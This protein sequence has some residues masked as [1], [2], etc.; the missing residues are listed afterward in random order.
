MKKIAGT[1]LVIYCFLTTA[2]AQS[3]QKIQLMPFAEPGLRDISL[4]GD[5]GIIIDGNGKMFRSGDFFQTYEIDSTYK[6]NGLD[7]MSFANRNEGYITS[8][9]VA[10]GILKT[11]DGGNTWYPLSSGQACIGEAVTFISADTGYSAARALAHQFVYTFNAGQNWFGNDLPS[12]LENIGVTRIERIQDSLLYI[13]C[14]DGQGSS[15][16]LTIYRTSNYGANWQN[17]FNSIWH[18]TGHCDFHFIDDTTLILVM[19]GA[20]LKSKDSGFTFDTVM[21]SDRWVDFVNYNV[22]AISFLGRDTGFVAYSH[23]VYRT[24]DAGETWIKTDFAFDSIDQAYGNEI[25]FIK[26]VT[27]KKVI[28]GCYRG[29]IYKTETGGGV[30]AGITE[31]E[32]APTFNLYPNPATHQLTI[33]TTGYNSN[34]QLTTTTGQLLLQGSVT[35]P[36]FTID[37]STLPPGLYFLQLTNGSQRSIR[38][39]VKQ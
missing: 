7:G 30:W 37:V 12:G 21:L 34:Y 36:N 1:V 29:N 25:T 28:L 5:T 14:V 23:S 16:I 20:I 17:V 6:G 27:S 22:R 15:K 13:S 33:K 11:V 10:G 18:V 35:Q 26:A 4:W 38:K 39:F 2:L 31:T 24:F 3:W 8:C 19:D 32:E 9:T